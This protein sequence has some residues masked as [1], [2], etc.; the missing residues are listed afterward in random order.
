MDENARSYLL[1]HRSALERD[2]KTSYIMDHMI[3]DEV[4]TLQEENRVK[5]ET[6]QTKRAAVLLQIL[7]EKDNYA[8]ISFYNAL[9]HEGYKDLAALLQDGIPVL[10]SCENKIVDGITSYVQTVLCEGGV[11]QRP[12]VCVARPELVKAVQQKLYCLRNESGWVT[13]HGMAGCGKSVLAAEVLRDH[14]LLEDCFPRGVHWVSVGK[15]DKAGLLLKLQNL[16]IRLDQDLQFSQRPPLNTEEAKDRLRLLITRK[17]PRSLLVLD[18]IWDSW[19]LKAF[20]IQCR[21][22]LTSRDKSVADAVSGNKH[23]VSVESGLPLDKGLEV[24]SLFVNMKIKDLPSEADTIVKECKGS[25]LVV[26]LIGALLRDFPNRWEYYV[27][28]LQNKQFKRIR[29]SSSYEFEALDE[30]MSISVEM[31]N[32]YLRNYYKDLSILVKDVKVP[33]KVLCTLWDMETEEVEDI[34]QE[35]VNK[36]LLFC[37]RNGKTFL[38]YLHDLQLDFLTE[39]NREQLPDLHA[40]MVKQYQ[41]YYERHLPKLDQEDC[42]YWYNFL[43]YHMASA[44]MHKELCSLLFSLDWLKA[45]TELL[46]PA[47]LIHEC[48]EYRHILDEQASAVRENF[49]EFLSLNGHLLGRSPLPD[50]L[51]LGLSQPNSSE[52]YKQA[53]SQAIQKLSS[54]AFYI[55][56]VNKMNIQSLSRLVVRPHTD[57]VYHACFS[58]DGQ[59]IASCG[60]DKTLQIFKT[61]TGE[62]LLEIKAHDDEVLFCAFSADN[63]YIATCSADKKVK[64]WNSRLG[65]LFRIYD[66]HTEQV[67]CCQFTSIDSQP[68]LATCSNDCFLKFWDLNM[69]HCRNTMIGHLNA[70]IHCRFSPDDK[71]LASCSADGTLKFWDVSGNELKSIDVRECFRNQ[72]EQQE[73]L[74]VLV[75]CCC[76]SHD[77]ARIMAAAKNALF[78]FDVET[79]DLLIELRTSYL[80]TIQYC[81]YAPSS[82]SIALAL[83]H[84]S[85]ELWNIETSLKIA[86]C[87]GHLSWVHCV[88]FSPDGSSFLTS[89]DDQTIRVWETSKVCKSSGMLLKREMDV[90][91]SENDVLVLVPDRTKC[92]LL[93]DGKSGSIL[94]RTEAQE[95][96]I[97]CCCLSKDFKLAAF[98]DEAGIVKV[99]ELPSGRVLRS[100]MGHKKSVQHCQFTPDGQTLISS[101]DDATIEVWEWQ[102]ENC[103]LLQGHKEAVKNFELLENSRLLSWSFDGTVKVWNIITGELESDFDCHNGAV[104]SCAV[105]NDTFK[106]SSTSAN[107][108]AKIWCFAKSTSLHHLN[109]HQGCVRCC[110]FSFDD[111]YLATGD[112]NGE[113]RIWNVSDGELLHLYSQVVESDGDIAHGGWVTDVHFSPDS[114]MLISTGGYVKW[115]KVD[116]GESLQTFYTHGTNLKSIY[117]SPTFRVYVTIDN[118]GILYVLEMLV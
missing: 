25:P 12:V 57:A 56:W 75:K 109:G 62:K 35:F 118:L 113:I 106:F 41:R 32:E 116:T 26:S 95:S 73:D 49:Q 39:K 63:K 7:L 8:Y 92:L 76:W 81:D 104:L 17:Y 21:I 36:S 112:D 45:K 107:K 13:I 4:L 37:D 89:S 55:E 82:Q 43:A 44:K 22:L 70:V 78:I 79:T 28:Q 102:S 52:I 108:S 60:G 29:K 5:F 72:D 77:C 11:P 66:E 64:V 9:V 27:R 100:M 2:I 115:W 88:A 80:S 68:L 85:V 31:L 84:Y 18:D 93:I 91:F 65:K 86:D 58:S 15:Q 48:I 59:N 90:V 67:N 47:H 98:G 74:D 40:K 71:Y 54:G 83:S 30:A 34:L 87:A 110:T 50:I 61:E 97:T 105:S 20:D 38:Y 94:S 99:L 111:Q 19:V 117:V 96:S 114:K 3:N 42:M 23:L 101:S 69:K 6:S 46:G 103:I 14:R 53:K 10:S 51:Q 24:L 1:R 16:C 33:T